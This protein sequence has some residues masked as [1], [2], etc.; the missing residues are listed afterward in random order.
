MTEPL[1]WTYAVTELPSGIRTFTRDATPEERAAISTDMGLIACSRLQASYAIRPL[2]GGRYKLSGSLRA[3]VT[4]A[5]VVTLEPLEATVNAPLDVEFSP[6]ANDPISPSNDDEIEV[7]S[8]PELEAIENGDLPV[9]RI[10]YEALAAAL[11]PYPKK[12]GATFA[13]DDPRAKDSKVHPFAALANLK[14]KE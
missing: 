6:S 2:G 11:D 8:L 4:Q 14:L 9:G 3:D 13:W 1:T 5:C 10:V 7:L 12:P